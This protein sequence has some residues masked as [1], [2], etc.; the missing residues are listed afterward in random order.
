MRHHIKKL[1]LFS[2]LAVGF[3]FFAGVPDLSAQGRLPDLT[4]VKISVARD[5][6]LAVVVRNNGPGILPNYVY[7]RHHPKSAGVFVFING[8]RWG[9]EAIWKFDP[10]R[11]LQKPGGQATCI[12]NYRVGRRISVRAVVDMHNDVREANERN[13]RRTRKR[14]RCLGGGGQAKLP[15]LIVRDIR[16]VKGCKI[17]VSV[18]NIGTAGVPD[19]FYDL[20]KAVGVQMYNNGKPWGGIILSGFDPA[21]KLKTPGGTAT[22][23]WFPLAANLNLGAG[24]H[25]IKVI[26]D[27]NKVLTESNETNNSL[28]RRLACKIQAAPQSMTPSSELVTATPGLVKAPQRFFLDFTDAYLAYKIS[29][30]SIQVIAESNVLSYGSDW[31]KCQ[32]GRTLFH[33]RQK[34]WKGFFWEVDIAKKVV[35]RIDGGSFCKGGGSKKALPFKVDVNA[36]FFYLRLTKAYLVYVPASKTL[37]VVSELMVLSYGGDWQKC[38]LSANVYHLKE[39]FWSNGNFYWKIDTLKKKAWRVKNNPFCKPGGT[40]TPLK[41]SVRVVN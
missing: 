24:I 30:K 23:I 37:Q 21:G 26:V 27:H 41:A 29:T 17:Q 16:L 4:I 6:K 9:G 34:V 39:N 36:G 12:L 33:L 20:P 19:S 7:T 1:T 22:H 28:V 2:V 25:S 3:L 18:T 15:D 32:L 11:K 14:L 38:N 31:E 40:K 8:R 10:G 5:C 35:Y 13:N